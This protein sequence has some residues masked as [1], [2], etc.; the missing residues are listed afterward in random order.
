MDGRLPSLAASLGTRRYPVLSSQ[1]PRVNLCAVWTGQWERVGTP[2][3]EMSEIIKKCLE[4]E[5]NRY[6]TWKVWK[7]N[8]L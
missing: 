8:P 3:D 5:K 4:T 2:E 7:V 1:I 6:K